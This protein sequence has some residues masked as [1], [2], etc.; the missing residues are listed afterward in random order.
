MSLTCVTLAVEDVLSDAVATKILESCGFKIETRLR[1]RGNT[2]LKQKAPELNRAAARDRPVF[3]LTDLDSPKN[4]PLD[5]IQSWIKG[6][7]KPGFF[8]RVAVMEVESWVL[9]DR[10]AVARFL[11]VPANQIPQR[12]DEVADPKRRI[13]SLAQKS[14]S[15]TI[16]EAL[17]PAPE[18][19]APVGNE[20]N[21]RLIEFVRESWDLERAASVSP[22]LKRT[23]ERLRQGS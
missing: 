21:A 22:S 5:L 20:Y 1:Q 15:R 3:L 19:T 13:V 23:L 2:Y 16:R 4:C 12:T 7:P 14:R 17:V 9:A 10:G 11:S 18:S 6:S 8:F